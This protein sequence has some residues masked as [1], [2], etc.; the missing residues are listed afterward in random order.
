MFGEGQ[1]L[2]PNFL[3]LAGAAA[4]ASSLAT[5]VV[6]VAMASCRSA[7]GVS[8]GIR[9][10]CCA[11]VTATTSFGPGTGFATGLGTVFAA[12]FRPGA[13]D[14]AVFVASDFFAAAP[15]GFTTPPFASAYALRISGFKRPRS[16]TSKPSA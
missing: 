4:A 7:S 3:D 6:R 12:D 10:T 8:S 9:P 11:D 14:V 15:F 13:F 1:P 2:R 5:R 16:A